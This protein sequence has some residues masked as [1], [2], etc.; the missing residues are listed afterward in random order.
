MEVSG[1]TSVVSKCEQ[2]K[3]MNKR[4]LCLA[5]C[6]VLF[7]LCFPA[8]AQQQSKIPKIGWLGVR[9]VASDTGPELFRREFRALGYVEGKNIVF[10]YR[11]ADDKLDRL[12]TL[13]DELVRL[14]VDVLLASATPAAVAAKNATRTIP[15]VFYGGFDPVAL[16]LVD[17]LARPGGNVTGFTSIAVVLVGKRLELLKETVPKL[18]RVALLWNPR[19]P[20]SAR[21]WKE[22]QVAARELGLQLHSMEVG[23]AEKL[24]GAFK[25]AT[26]TRSAALATTSS[27]FVDN[28]KKPIADLAAKSRL[29][30]IYHQASFIA[31]GGL[32]SYGADD[33]EHYRRVAVIVDKILKRRQARGS[34]CRATEE[35]RVYH[36]SEGCKADRPNDS[37]ECVSAG[38]SSNSVRREGSGVNVTVRH[39]REGSRPK[40]G[41]LNG[42]TWEK[43]RSKY[44]GISGTGSQVIVVYDQLID[45]EGSLIRIYE[46]VIGHVVPGIKL[47]FGH[48]VCAVS[49]G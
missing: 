14:K 22:S 37:A 10:E 34:S 2:K 31:D 38:G 27:A 42:K 6:G 23:S 43:R 13:A 8:D 46:P 25:E 47:G 36:Q 29:P 49:R 20:G 30:A 41:E 18:S 32:M 24:D 28:H 5:L 9:P 7:A 3:S 39:K 33:T 19:D 45:F 1:Q 16:G 21:Q 44:L 12:T 48:A 26:K 15:I 40:I 35:V 11:S 4:I 17:S